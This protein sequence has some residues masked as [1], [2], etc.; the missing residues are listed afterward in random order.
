MRMRFA[1]VA[2]V[3]ALL[4]LAAWTA[5][6]DPRGPDPEQ[7]LSGLQGRQVLS[8][9]TGGSA[10][11]CAVP[12][13]WRLAR[14]DDEFGL[15][16][17]E[18]RRAIVEAAG[19]WEAA[20]ARPLFA[21]DPSEGFPIRFVYD[22]RQA[23]MGERMRRQ[24]ELD[25]FRERLRARRAE[26]PELHSRLR[27]LY[28]ERQREHERRTG[29][30]NATVR[31]WNA[32]GGVPPRVL[33]ELLEA[34]EALQVER[35]A[36]AADREALEGTGGALRD[37]QERSNDEFEKYALQADAL[38]REFP[39]ASIESGL[40]REAVRTEGGSVASVS[41]EIRIYRFGGSDDLVLVA[42]HE[43]GH[44]LGLGHSAEPGSIMSEEHRGQAASSRT[45]RS[46]GVSGLQ[47][48]DLQLFRERCPD[49]LN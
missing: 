10:V 29:S 12:L 17:E 46:V 48:A 26:Q 43:F 34:G 39:S 3:P 47:A 2:G 4:G 8:D 16:A 32:R 23:R 21:H 5:R 11:P 28:Q 15:G 38:Q 22:E 35:R 37:L 14:L 13:T 30:H 1:I 20:V 9:H 40:Y 49:L 45:S 44:A 25:D 42:A 18:A 27:A 36:L 24:A 41:R 19:L 6:P 31:D 33:Q 7:W